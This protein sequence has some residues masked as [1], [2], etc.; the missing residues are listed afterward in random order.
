[1]MNDDEDLGRL[2]DEE[3]GN[4]N[5]AKAGQL[6]AQDAKNCHIHHCHHCHYQKFQ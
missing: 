1:M 5:I 3:D 4:G 2:N 6:R